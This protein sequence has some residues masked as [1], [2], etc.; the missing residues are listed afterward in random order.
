M[1]IKLLVIS[2]ILFLQLKANFS[3][4]QEEGMLMYAIENATYVKKEYNTKGV[5]SG[6]QSFNL[7][8]ISKKDAN[9]EM[10]IE[11]KSY[12]KKG[13]FLEKFNTKYYCDPKDNSLLMNII[14]F[15]AFTSNKLIQINS[16]NELKL[17]PTN[18]K[19]GLKMKDLTFSL[20]IKGGA[21][22][23]FSGESQVKIF[24]REVT[25]SDKNGNF[26]I[27]SKMKIDLYSFGVRIKQLIYTI[28]ETIHPKAGV[29]WQKFTSQDKSYFTIKKIN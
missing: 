24:D 11:V 6:S 21:I 15:A 13:K 14:P 18:W 19:V 22:G 23:L 7:G 3:F 29:K 12:D 20:N 4:A 10:P 28:S 1:K 25:S 16:D 8:T 5:F 27:R 9:Y 2:T 17:Y 26:S